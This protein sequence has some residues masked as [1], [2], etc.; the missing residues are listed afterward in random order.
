[1]APAVALWPQE[2]V[3][4]ALA[5]GARPDTLA[6]AAAGDH[7][8]NVVAVV[9]VDVVVDV[10]AEGGQPRIVAAAVAGCCVALRVAVTPAVLGRVRV[11]TVAARPSAAA[12]VRVRRMKR[13]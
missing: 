2:A 8:C 3:P 4:P 5:V 10:A 6:A 12:A 9:V 7:Q 11:S 13:G 1:M